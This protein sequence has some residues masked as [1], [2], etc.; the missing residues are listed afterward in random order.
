MLEDASS[1][2]ENP[3]PNCGE[4]DFTWGNLVGAGFV[5]SIWA[6]VPDGLAARLCD[7]CGNIQLFL[8]REIQDV[9]DRSKREK[10]K[11]GE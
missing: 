7:R 9:I 5:K 4:T 10:R 8:K 3:C 6:I 1:L 11:R 2:A